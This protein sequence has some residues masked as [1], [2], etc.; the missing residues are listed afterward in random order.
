MS[1]LSS[2]HVYDSNWNE[3]NRQKFSND[4]LKEIKSAE[5]IAV[6]GV[7]SQGIPAGKALCFY[8][9]SGKR[10]IGSI[11][12]KVNCVVGDIVDPASVV[13]VTYTKEGSNPCTKWAW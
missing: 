8:L 12:T 4:E 7:P 11:D 10:A 6:K 9:V 1:I 3:S 13:A 2:L 5:V